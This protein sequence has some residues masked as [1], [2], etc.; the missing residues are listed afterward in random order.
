MP[1]VE[2]DVAE[3]CAFLHRFMAGERGFTS[4][5]AVAGV[6]RLGDLQEHLRDPERRRESR[7]IA[8]LVCQKLDLRGPRFDWAQS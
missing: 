6:H 7:E 2:R 8:H 3:A 4:K 1:F 5:D